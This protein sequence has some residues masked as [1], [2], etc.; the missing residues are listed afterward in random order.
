MIF[1]VNL[2]VGHYA[3]MLNDLYILLPGKEIRL[4]QNDQMLK[5]VHQ[6][7]L[8][9]YETDH[10][11]FLNSASHESEILSVSWCISMSSYGI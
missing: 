11:K 8:S 3:S 1:N 9:F 10:P 5:D 6:Q 7:L 4:R 2:I